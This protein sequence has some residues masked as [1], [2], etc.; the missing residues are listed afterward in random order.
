MDNSKYDY[1]FQT[2]CI[3]NQDDDTSND[4]NIIK[5]WFVGATGNDDD[6]NYT[7]FAEKYI[8]ESR[9]ENKWE[10]KFIDKVNEIKVGDRIVLKSS[11]TKKNNL[12]FKNNGKTVSVMA[13]KAIGTVKS[14][15]Q[16]GHN[17]DVEWT[18]IKPIK[19]WYG[20]GV[21]RET[22]HL[23][24]PSTEIKKALLKFV[25]EDQ[26]QDYL[27]CEEQ[28]IEDMCD[29]ESDYIENYN[30][31]QH[32]VSLIQNII[33]YGTPGCGKSYYVK[34]KLLKEYKNDNIIRTTFYQDYTNTDFVGQI[35]PFVSGET[36]TYKFNPG[37]FTI[38]LKKA[39]NHPS[40]NVALVIEELNRGNAPSIFGDIFQLL[41]R[42][43]GKS[44]YQITNVNVQKYLEQENPRYSFNNVVIP[45]NLSIVATM[46]TSDQNVFTL[47]TAFKRRW[48]F[49]K[50]KNIFTTSG[51]DEHPYR[52]YYV[53]GMENT[54]W[55]EFVDAINDFIINTSTDLQS[56]DKQLGVFF[57]D[58]SLLCK[59]VEDTN[60]IKI[61][62]FAYKVLEYLW[63]DVAKFDR[64]S[65]FIN[66]IRTLDELVDKYIELGAGVFKDGVFKK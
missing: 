29:N 5:A 39:I 34:N 1:N 11:Y 57:V 14:N 48:D 53:P 7:D 10:T 61:L 58:E 60:D 50:L 6:G 55:Q 26:Q 3:D 8:A 40:E 64:D 2:L 33:I 43:D 49:Y 32:K 24:E 20:A 30:Y 62:K 17:I 66:S 28:Y 31:E 15:K 45:S 21:M 9:W 36:V 59:T 13:I 19:E 37:P 38:A 47:D 25:F 44:E 41:D 56:E 46:N 63:D 42:K 35:L 22:I 16:D 52:N 4:S 27:L 12:P 51:E 54:T 65:W 18:S 23:V